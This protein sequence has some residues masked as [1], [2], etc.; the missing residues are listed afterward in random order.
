MQR[1]A[2]G[3]SAA[4]IHWLGVI[5]PAALAVAVLLDGQLGDWCVTGSWSMPTESVF[6]A[7]ASRKLEAA[8][9]T[10]DMV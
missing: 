6:D 5:W 10:P 7:A 9:L 4:T 3:P 8:Y 2:S 1:P